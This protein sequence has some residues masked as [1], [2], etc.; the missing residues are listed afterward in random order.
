MSLRTWCSV[1]GYGTI[2]AIVDAAC[3]GLAA[4]AAKDVPAASFAAWFLVVAY[5]SIAFGAQCPFGLAVDRWRIPRATAILGCGVVALGV[6]LFGTV[7]Y[8]ALA[9]AAI[10][11]ALFHIG[12]G[13]ISLNQTPNRATAPGLFVAP[14]WLG[15]NVG[16]LL[17]TGGHFTGWWFAALLLAACALIRFL[18]VPS[19]D[20]SPRSLHVGGGAYAAALGLLLLAILVRSL[21]G[22]AAV[23]PWKSNT[24]LFLMLTLAVVAGKALGGIL[25]DRFG[26]QKVAVASLLVS[27]PLISMGAKWPLLAIPG[28]LLFQVTMPVTLAGVSMLLPGRSSFAFGLASLALIL[29]AFPTFTALKPVFG[30][31]VLILFLVLLSTAALFQALRLLSPRPFSQTR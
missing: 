29:G 14:G 6:T 7:P 1:I 10:G 12:A 18:E 15:L 24:N 2:H 17:G 28:M 16:M 4:T 25:A 20:Y 5:D 9:L 13:S 22:L 30:N 31:H 3:A 19:M 27:A 8:L 11:N 21:V 26:W 23:F